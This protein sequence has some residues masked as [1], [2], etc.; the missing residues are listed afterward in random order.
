[1]RK[2]AVLAVLVGGSLFALSAM[3]TTD[4]TTSINAATWYFGAQGGIASMNQNIGTKGNFGATAGYKF[5]P[6]W[7]AAL[8]TNYTPLTGAKMMMYG[9]EGNYFFTGALEGLHVGMKFGLA[10]T[11][12]DVVNTSFS[13]IAWGPKVAYDWA[14]TKGWSL[15]AETGMMFLPSKNTSQTVG[16][17]TVTINQPS[18]TAF[19]FTA[20]IKYWL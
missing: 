13:R 8:Y 18:V 3:A 9:V 6:E 19:G 1:M 5:G 16:T 2:S 7:G 10:N 4:T 11:S 14:F 17:T 20:A 15:G 12:V